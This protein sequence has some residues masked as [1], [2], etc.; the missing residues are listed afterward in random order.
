MA[1]I[2]V[3][4]GNRGKLSEIRAL[5]GDSHELIVQSDLDVP[6][7]EET[8]LTFVENAILK[9]RNAAQ[10]TGLAAIGEDSGLE[11]DALSGAPGIFSARYAGPGATDTDN[12]QKLLK[13]L[14]DA[15]VR[16]ARYRCLAVFMRHADDPAPLICQGAWE[17]TIALTPAGDL[18]F[19]YDPVFIPAGSDHTVAQ[20]PT[21]EKN[22][23]SHRAQALAQLVRQ[24][25]ACIT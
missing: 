6:E 1:K 2:V 18:G 22:R 14:A 5:L 4:T 15:E 25:D 13:T 8:G 24:L 7:A 3:A 20:M 12:N 23:V 19:G 17:G 9:A 21:A 16:A 11:V 10:H